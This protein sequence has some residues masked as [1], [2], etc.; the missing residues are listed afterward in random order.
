M[1]RPIKDNSVPMDDWGFL[2]RIVKRP[3]EI[4]LLGREPEDQRKYVEILSETKK[5]WR[6][7]SDLLKVDKFGFAKIEISGLFASGDP[8]QDLKT[9]Q[10][11]RNDYPYNFGPSIDH[12][13]LWKFGGPIKAKEIESAMN[14]LKSEGRYG[15]CIYWIN[16]PHLKSI[17]DVDHAHIL[18]HK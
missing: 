9:L 1:G 11:H 10:I 13:C 8:P 5:K 4:F 12:Y 18:A 3:E 15:K 14:D 17:P 16:P 6:S 7:A 2:K